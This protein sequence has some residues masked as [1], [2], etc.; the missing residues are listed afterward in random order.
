MSLETLMARIAATSTSAG[1]LVGAIEAELTKPLLIDPTMVDAYARDLL[2]LGSTKEVLEP[3]LSTEGVIVRSSNSVTVSTFTKSGTA[4]LDISGPLISRDV[5]GP[6]SSSPVSYASI[7]AEIANAVADPRINNV[8]ARIDS[9][10][11]VASQM[12]DLADYIRETVAANPHMQFIACIDDVA[13]SAAFGIAAAFPV[14]YITRTG[15]AGS[16]GVVVKHTSAAVALE[17]AGLEDTYIFA[18]ANKV[19]GNGSQ[20]LSAEA[21]E[22]IKKRVMMHYDLFVDSVAD[23]IGMSVDAVKATEAATYQGQDAIDVGFA[24]GIKTFTQIIEELENG[25]METHT[26]NPNTPAANLAA[27]LANAGIDATGAPLAETTPVPAESATA[28]LATAA[29]IP[30]APKMTTDEI[31]AAA[32]KINADNDAKKQQVEADEKAA[33]ARADAITSI[34]EMGGIDADTM[35]KFIASD[36]S[37]DTIGAMV[38]NGSAG[39]TTLKTNRSQSKVEAATGAEEK[40]TIA[41]GWAEALK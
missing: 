29:T 17:K 23:G 8:V 24:T 26:N 1:K 4:V 37:A 34:C 19:L 41:S 2:T 3:V 9:G 7:R 10:G 40:A 35:G 38:A 14:R 36:M 18:G 21:F 30:A 16:V 11:G 25:K 31:L 28:T 6:C 33:T 32:A 20:P 39:G 15:V 13:A 12:V 22:M 27:A 5:H